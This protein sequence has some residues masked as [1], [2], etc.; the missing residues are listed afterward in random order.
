MPTPR[1]QKEAKKSRELDMLSDIENFAVML[2]EITSVIYR[3]RK[4]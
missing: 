4:A 1:K 3:E 2:G